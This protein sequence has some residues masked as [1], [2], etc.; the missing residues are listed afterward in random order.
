MR[1]RQR[2]YMHGARPT[3]P[4]E[5]HPGDQRETAGS[6]HPYALGRAHETAV[7]GRLERRG[8]L[9][10]RSYASKGIEDLLAF[11]GNV[12][13]LIQCKRTGGISSDEWN[14]LYGLAEEF[15]AVPVVTFKSG[16]RDVAFMR[17]DGRR[18]FR[19]HGRPWTEVD[20]ATLE[21]V[22]VQLAVALAA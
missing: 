2:T 18:E 19:A 16:D 8:W 12:L 7:R 10:R 13:L 22:P 1:V 3:R 11:R 15:G 20:P 14:R 6:R 9:V 17:L 5:V 4:A 21:P